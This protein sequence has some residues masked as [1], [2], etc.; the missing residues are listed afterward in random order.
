MAVLAATVVALSAGLRAQQR[1]VYRSATE[2]ILVD[3]Q[4]VD[5]RGDPVHGLNAADFRV[6]IDR[7][8]RTVVS[9]DLIDHRVGKQL[10]SVRGGLSLLNWPADAPRAFVVAIDESSFHARHAPAAVRAARRFI[11]NLTPADHVGL[12]T[13]PVHGPQLELTA[14]HNSVLRQLDSVVGVLDVPRSNYRV[15]L[16]EV[17]DITG[18]Q[19]DV[20]ERVVKRECPVQ[21]CYREIDALV[22]ELAV[23]FELQVSQS[24]GGLR[25]LIR[26]LATFPARKIVVLISGGLLASDRVG[27]RPDVGA[28]I[29]QVGEEASR[30]NIALF[31]IHLDSSFIEAFSAGGGTVGASFMRESAALAAGLERFA[32]TAGGALFRVEAGN[33][34]YAFERV[35]R[36]TS[37]YYLLGVES[38]PPDRDGRPHYL[39]VR[40]DRS[41]VEVRHRR[42][43]LIPGGK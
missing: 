33:G 15:S 22:R 6:R 20:L 7:S 23:A 39:D 43:V 24:V 1:P 30:S 42:S 35:L 25:T 8:D 2:N 14:D 10:P 32:G 41:S 28:L 11:E 31:V 19:V 38:L 9:A 12:Y 26:T 3:V 18:G 13:Y 40:V 37:A 36:E 27:G 34:D 21:P 17:V 16:S 5:R 29:Q 4:V